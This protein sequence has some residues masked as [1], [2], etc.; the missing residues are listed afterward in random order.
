MQQSCMSMDTKKA[1]SEK[2]FESNSTFDA[3]FNQK[4]DKIFRLV[5]RLLVFYRRKHWLV[6]GSLSKTNQ[7][8]F[9]FDDVVFV[10]FKLRFYL[11]F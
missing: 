11:P 3:A 5:Q 10:W 8:S 7:S 9:F 6:F 2:K 4:T 1:V